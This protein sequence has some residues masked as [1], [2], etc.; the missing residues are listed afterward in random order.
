MEI[1]LSFRALSRAI[2]PTKYSLHKRMSGI[3]YCFF[4]LNNIHAQNYISIVNHTGLSRPLRVN[5]KEAKIIYDW[6][7][8]VRNCTEIK[9]THKHRNNSFNIRTGFFSLGYETF[10]TQDF[11]DDTHILGAGLPIDYANKLVID[12]WG[13]GIGYAHTFGKKITLESNLHYLWPITVYTTFT[14]AF[15]NPVLDPDRGF[16]ESWTYIFK[17]SDA[18]LHKYKNQMVASWAGRYEMTKNLFF[19]A[20]YL[21]GFSEFNPYY[22]RLGPRPRLHQFI[23]IGLEY[24]IKL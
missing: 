8:L 19:S 2:R 18:E 14:Y 21:I 23:G 4:L 5:H 3:V 16:W 9:F 22:G 13:A 15:P 20:S 17:R 7:G 10:T 1:I 24:Q 11:T 12:Y 6:H